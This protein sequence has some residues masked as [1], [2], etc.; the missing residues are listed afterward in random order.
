[1]APVL[2]AQSGGSFP[3][4]RSRDGVHGHRVR[5]RV[6]RLAARTGGA[7]PVVAVAQPGACGP[8]PGGADISTPP[9]PTFA[10][11]GGKIVQSIV[12]GDI[13]SCMGV[14][15]A[16]YLAHGAGQSVNPNSYF[17]RFPDRPTARIIALP[18]YL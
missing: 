16:A 7:G 1:R 9:A 4:R 3:V 18:A 2:G 6:G 12:F 11:V 15:R 10:I 14:V 8:D 5:R 13:E 17:L